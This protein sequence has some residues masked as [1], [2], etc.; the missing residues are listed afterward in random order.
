MLTDEQRDSFFRCGIFDL[1]TDLCQQA[2]GAMDPADPETTRAVVEYLEERLEQ[3]E[4]R[5]YNQEARDAAARAYV[6]AALIE[7]RRWTTEQPTTATSSPYDPF[8]GPVVSGHPTCRSCGRAKL[9]GHKAACMD[10]NGEVAERI[11]GWKRYTAGVRHLGHRGPDGSP[12]ATVM[13]QPPGWFRPDKKM[14]GGTMADVYKPTTALPSYIHGHPV[15]PQYDRDWS[16]TIKV[17]DVMAEDDDL[18]DLFLCH[19]VKLAGIVEL[20]PRLVGGGNTWRKVDSAAIC[21]AAL[22]ALHDQEHP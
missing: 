8:T 12:T 15:T 2:N 5:R 4:P 19:L 16:A 18:W 10:L 22:R 3:W 20:E 14:Q 21:H 1:A 9:E 17:R 7:Y 6:R 11:F 13:L